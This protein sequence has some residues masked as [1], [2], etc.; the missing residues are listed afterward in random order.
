MNLLK[1]LYQQHE[2]KS[3]DKWNIY[4]DVYDELLSNRRAQLSNFLEIGVQNG[5][6]LEIWSK[7]FP[8]AKNLI[9]CDINP[10]CA[11]LEYADS[12]IKVIIGDSSSQNV[13]N[14]IA[15]ITPD[16]DLIIDDGSHTSS[17]IIKSFLLYFPLV[18]DGGIYIIEDLHASYWKSFEGGLY[19]PYSSMAFLK[20]LSD[21]TNY[22]H[23]GVELKPQDYLSPFFKYY[24]CLEMDIVDYSNIHSVTFVNSLC[25]IKK[26]RSEFNLLG[27]RHI[28]GNE[29]RV[30][31]SNKTS[32]GKNIRVIN[33]NEN[34]WGKLSNFPEMEWGGL[35]SKYN[36]KKKEVDSLIKEI[37]SVRN[38][39]EIKLTE[40]GA[41][42]KESN[43]IRDRLIKDNT[44]ILNS[45]SWKITQP[46][47]S[48]INI[49]KRR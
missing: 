25:I 10:A 27:P 17:D 38:E 33:Q 15:S 5:G 37:E 18:S 48:L 9:G 22:E 7:Y 40:L 3:S 30:F 36:S 35:V 12:K 16:I 19:Y 20:K 1:N 31:E 26:N 23:W 49:I 45:T 39:Y 41:K 43:G 4:L 34:Y 44:E 6:S 42:I 13:K 21:I 47:R 8:E 11:G 32:Q 2:G 29:W 46:L 24:N 14:E 28:A